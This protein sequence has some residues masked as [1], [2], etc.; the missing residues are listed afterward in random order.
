MKPAP[1]VYR[2]NRIRTL[3]LCLALLLAVLLNQKNRACAFTK[4]AIFVPTVLS[5]GVREKGR[6]GGLV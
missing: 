4:S 5:R 6:P 3:W 2:T 1:S